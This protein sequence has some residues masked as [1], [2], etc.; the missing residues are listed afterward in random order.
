MGKADPLALTFC[1]TFEA[2]IKE[3]KL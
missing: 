3:D 1:Q 2:D